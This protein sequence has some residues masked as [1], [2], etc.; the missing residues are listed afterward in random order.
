MSIWGMVGG[1]SLLLLVGAWAYERLPRWRAADARARREPLTDEQFG[2]RFFPPD[3]SR[4]AARLKRLA[5]EQLGKELTRLHPD[6]LLAQTLSDD[7]DSLDSVELLLAIEDEL[8]IEL[9]DAVVADIKTFRDLVTAVAARRPFLMKWRLKLG[10]AIE[11]RFGISLPREVLAKLATPLEVVEAVAAELK[12]QVGTQKSCPNQRAFYLLRNALM[13]TLG[14]PRGLITPATRLCRL[15]RRRTA[16]SVWTQLREAVGARQWP[17]L[18]RPQW[19]SW[20]VYGVPFLNAAVVAI[21]LPFFADRA[22][23]AG[24]TVGFLMSFASELRVLVAIAVATGTWILLVRFSKH[25]NR[26]LPCNLRTVGDL[27][28]FV[29]TSTEM[30]WTRDQIEDELRRIV[31]TQLQAPMEH[32]Q[33]GGRFV[34]DLRMEPNFQSE[35]LWIT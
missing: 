10:R 33:A 31:V 14:V 29:M 5:S 13:R 21:S 34:E 28:P 25:F 23:R 27:V 1:G 4:I 3:L 16:R 24:E 26:A 11:E 18:V 22:F 35:H 17:P 20:V 15:I 7:F 8:G 30:T 32:Y 6:D 12:N 2:Q 19:M 9:D